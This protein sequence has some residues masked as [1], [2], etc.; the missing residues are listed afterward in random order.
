M[1]KIIF[2][3]YV[4]I[5]LS[6]L[7]YSQ[8][9]FSQN[10]LKGEEK[11][12]VIISKNI[13]RGILYKESK[14]VSLEKK[15]LLNIPLKGKQYHIIK[16]GDVKL[17]KQE[18]YIL[19]RISSDIYVFNE[20]CD[21]LRSIPISPKPSKFGAEFTELILLKSSEMLIRN[22]RHSEIYHIDNNGRVITKYQF[23]D[24]INHLAPRNMDYIITPEGIQVFSVI[25]Q[26]FTS[27]GIHKVFTESLLVGRFNENGELIDRY[28]NYDPIYKKYN[29]LGFQPS[30]IRICNN[31]IYH[32]QQ[33]LP[34]IRVYSLSGEFLFQFGEP[35]Y[36]M[37]PIEKQI[38]YRNMEQ[39]DAFLNSHT[40]YGDIYYL[41]GCKGYDN[42]FLL[43][44]Y[45]N[46]ISSQENK[47]YITLYTLDGQLLYND[48]EIPGVPI[49]SIENSGVIVVLKHS[50]TKVSIEKYSLSIIDSIEN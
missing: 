8:E 4:N 35:G 36:H 30:S 7:N 6:Y 12:A 50:S 9:L 22:A 13:D 29:L 26:T 18:I 43:I 11:V 17:F 45:Q 40:L 39:F 46:P 3:I 19:D 21:F 24:N 48:L 31:R 10:Y 15:E 42:P 23:N 5:L 44:Y 47:Y 32:I 34:F 41:K 20:E 16:K 14:K 27:D 37:R 1:L 49:Q 2:S 25:W 28:I 38:E 33:A